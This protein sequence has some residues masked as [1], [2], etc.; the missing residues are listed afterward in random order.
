MLETATGINDQGRII[1][2]GSMNGYP[3]AFLLV[4][5]CGPADIAGLG[6]TQTPDGTL[7]PDDLVAYLAAFFAGNAPVADIA[8][9]GGA[10]GPDGQVTVD[11]LV[12]YLA[13]FFSGCP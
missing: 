11:D 4:P 8:S 3:R 10:F 13:A 7:T 5:H 12:A 6:G 9:L 1:G 2:S